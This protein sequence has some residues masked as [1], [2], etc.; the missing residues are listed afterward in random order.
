MEFNSPEAPE[1]RV[2]SLNAMTDSDRSTKPFTLQHCSVGCLLRVWSDAVTKFDRRESPKSFF[3]RI[4]GLL[5]SLLTSSAAIKCY[6][7]NWLISHQGCLIIR[8]HFCL[9]PL[10]TPHSLEINAFL[11]YPCRTSPTSSR[12]GSDRH[13]SRRHSERTRRYLPI[14]PGQRHCLRRRCHYL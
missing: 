11:Y 3:M 14:Q 9:G 1:P 2:S 5:T 4:T 10:K 8:S 13:T 12:R 7:R 6:S